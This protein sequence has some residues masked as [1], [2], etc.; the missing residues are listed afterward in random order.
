MAPS[1]PCSPA[2]VARSRL[3]VR[4]APLG[5][6]AREMSVNIFHHDDGRIDH[7]SEIDGADREQVRGFAANDENGDR[8]KKRE[9]DRHGDDQRATQISEEQ[10]LHDEDQDDP[11][12][13][14]FQHGAGGDVDEIGAVVDRL[15]MNARRQDVGAVDVCDL[16]LNSADRGHALLAALHEH[17]A[18]HDVV[19]IVLAC[20]AEARLMADGDGRDVAQ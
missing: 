5:G 16:C 13:H 17:D 3:L 19:V 4:S 18:L 20:D 15:D 14:V 11:H 1:L 10:P 8:E 9:R 7:Q 12:R 2:S 6:A